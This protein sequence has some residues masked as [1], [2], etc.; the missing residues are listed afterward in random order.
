VRDFIVTPDGRRV[1]GAFFNH[2]E[3][4]YRAEWLEAFQVRQREAGALTLVLQPS[5][6][7]ERSELD[8]LLGELARGLGED[9]HIELE[10]VEAIAR[11]KAGKYR[12]IVSELVD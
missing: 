12:L 7:P 8:A 10:L 2:F 11:G 1:H 4:F 5:R 6:K 9:M 3:P